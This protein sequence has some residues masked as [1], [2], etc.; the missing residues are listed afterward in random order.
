MLRRSNLKRRVDKI[1][2]ARAVLK[3][4]ITKLEHLSL[5]CAREAATF[6][7]EHDPKRKMGLA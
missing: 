1:A 7:S 4:V 3:E 2:R 6:Q 5:A